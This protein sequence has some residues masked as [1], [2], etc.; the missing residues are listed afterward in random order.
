MEEYRLMEEAGEE[1]ELYM[2]NPYLFSRMQY[3]ITIDADKMMQRNDAFERAFKLETYDRAIQNPLIMQDMESQLKIT[4]DFLLEPLIRGEASKYL[5][6]IEKIM[7]GLVPPQ[8]QQ[9]GDM[10]KS[11]MQ[12]TALQSRP[13]L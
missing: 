5:P 9:G 2:V 10:A 11:M 8:Q 4:R 1:K 3:L 7:Q 12:S 13:V 6:N